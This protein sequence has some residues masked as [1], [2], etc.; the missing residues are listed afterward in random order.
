MVAAVCGWVECATSS[1]ALEVCLVQAVGATT[2]FARRMI[3]L[4]MSH[5]SCEKVLRAMLFAHREQQLWDRQQALMDRMQ[6]QWDEERR[7]SRKQSCGG[8]G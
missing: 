2:A 1:C 4:N 3:A 5:V 7:V 8:D 6:Q